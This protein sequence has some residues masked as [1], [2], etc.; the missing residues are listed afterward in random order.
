M[1]TQ[2]EAAKNRKITPQMEQVALE[3]KLSPEQVRQFVEEG[4]VVIPFNKDR[5]FRAIGIGRNMSTKTNANLGTSDDEQ[6]LEDELEKLRIAIEAGASTVMDLSTGGDIR[7]IRKTIIENSTVPLGTVPLYQ[8]VCE[9]IKGDSHLADMTADHIFNT[10]EQHGKD[11]VDYITVHCGVTK[12]S[13]ARIENEG[14]ILDIVSRG[15]AITSK[16]IKYTG[17]E[18]PLNE[19]FDR[20][21]EIAREYDMTLSL[22]DGL[23]PGCLSD[24]TDRGQVQE[25]IILGELAARAKKAGVQVMIEGPGHMPMD[26]IEANMVLMKRLCNNAP[27][28]VLGPLVTDVAP[29]YDHITAAIGGAIAARAGADFLCVVTPSEHLRLPTAEDIR[30]GVIAARIAAHA[31][32]ICKL[33]NGQ[34]EWDNRMALARKKLD[35]KSQIAESIN[36]KKAADFRKDSTPESD[37]D[38]CTMCSALC[39]IKYGDLKETYK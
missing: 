36:P 12:E 20:L 18:N 8:A 29:G 15:G 28:Y 3:E 27:F 1:T 24:A 7:H 26:Q 19:H 11:G 13:I 9:N 21:L 4:S 10:I 6:S 16:W 37:E 35:W 30:E 34:I 32:D 22:G 14:R 31:A 25:T 2:L 39:A 23:R 17:E 33:G 38:T 5:N